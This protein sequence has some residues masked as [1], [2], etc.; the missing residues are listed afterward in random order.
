MVQQKE[1]AKE[2]AERIRTGRKPEQPIVVRELTRVAK[3]KEVY[4]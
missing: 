3:D 1:T 2:I 4:I